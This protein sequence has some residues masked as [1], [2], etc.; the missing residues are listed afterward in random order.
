MIPSHP[1][2]S[3]R[4][5]RSLQFLLHIINPYSPLVH[6][7]S[8]SFSLTAPV[9]TQHHVE[10]VIKHPV[11]SF[12][13]RSTFSVAASLLLLLTLQLQLQLQFSS[14]AHPTQPRKSHPTHA[15]HRT[16]ETQFLSIDQQSQQYPTL[17]HTTQQAEDYLSW[18]LATFCR[19]E[20]DL[21]AVMAL[22]GTSSSSAMKLIML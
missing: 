8:S 13:I 12:P 21:R 11:P 6:L 17:H 10:M 19:F 7:F 2:P 9:D 16:R 4:T 5:D 15:P 14:I 1:I 22:V 18:I 3:H 20:S